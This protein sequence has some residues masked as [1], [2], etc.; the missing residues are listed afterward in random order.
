MYMIFQRK[1]LS[2]I[3]SNL[4]GFKNQSGIYYILFI[5]IVTYLLFLLGFK[6]W[7][8]REFDIEIIATNA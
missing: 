3:K 4:F 6:P 7:N 2:W 8:S 5:N 1:Y